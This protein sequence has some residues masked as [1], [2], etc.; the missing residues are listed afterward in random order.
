[1][2]TASQRATRYKKNANEIN[3]EEIVKEIETMANAHVNAS[4]PAQT[5]ADIEELLADLDLDTELSASADV[6]EEDVIEEEAVEAV[7]DEPVEATEEIEDL[8]I[9]VD[10]LEIAMKRSKSY[11]EQESEANAASDA[12]AAVVEAKAKAA[13][14]PKPRAAKAPRAASSKPRAAKSLADVGAEYFVLEGDPAALDQQALDDNKAAVI[15]TPITQIKVKEKFD[16]VITSLAR[17]AL[18]SVYVVQAFKL[19]DQK[20]TVTSQDVTAMYKA[21]GLKQGTAT[22][23]QGQIMNLFDL[24]K[25]ATRSKAQLTLNT[26][27]QIAKRIRDAI[28][29]YE[30]AKTVPAAA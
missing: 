7:A 20:G 11:S 10:S 5:A 4:V 17:G 23:Q 15:A 12:T 8:D 29:A 3:D 9:D 6:V 18:P 28:A 1:M 14:A 22:A 26:N 30:A 24:L 2:P 19:L 25:I 27:S 16:N 13:S 21:N